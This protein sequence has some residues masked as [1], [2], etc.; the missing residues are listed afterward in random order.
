MLYSDKLLSDM[1]M[2]DLNVVQ[3]G[4]HGMAES[5][6]IAGAACKHAALM[7]HIVRP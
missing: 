6:V 4:M 1:Q 7:T 5:V 3:A 2:S